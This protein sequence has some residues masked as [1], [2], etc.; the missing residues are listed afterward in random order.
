[1]T[2]KLTFHGAAGCVTG[3][4]ARLEAGRA[5]VLV[6][7]GMFQGSKTL[8]ALNYEPFPFD[9][10]AIDAVLLTHA[11]IDHSGLLPKLMKAGFEGP[12]Y[13]TAGTRDLCAVMLPDA[14]D[15]QESEVRQLNRRNQR[16]GRPEVEPIY[17]V[18]DARRCMELFR[19]V[20]LG[21]IAEVAPGI[22][23]TYWEAG[24]ILG[25]ASIELQVDTEEGP[26]SLMFSG[27]LG[28]GGRDYTPDPEGPV[29]VDHLILESTYGD[30]ER[31]TA[32]GGERRAL[33]AKELTEAHAAG[34]PLLI[35]AFAVERS[36]EL[37]ADIVTLME[38]RQVPEADIFLDSPLAIEATE[39]FQKRGWNR[40]TGVNPFEGL[41]HSGRLK[42]LNHPSESDQLD[43]LAGWHVII[44]ASGMCDAGRVRKHLKRLLWRR[45]ATVLI[46]GYQAVG[47]LGRILQEGA[48][49]VS[50]QGDDVQVRARIRSLDVYSGHADA[51]GLVAWAKAR[52]PVAGQIFLVHGE[53]AALDGLET[54]LE[55]A[56]FPAA[57]M[58]APAMDEAFLL[59]KTDAT[60]ESI[61]AR[62]IVAGAVAKADWHNARAQLLMELNERLSDAPNDRAREE[63]I[64]QLA[65]ALNRAS[66]SISSPSAVLLSAI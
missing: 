28:P 48:R 25:S 54:R 36:Q 17:A 50:I 20:K 63:I 8:K 66:S 65:G 19:K 60:S 16:R 6:D 21:E 24:H 10:H 55:T 39:V 33:L 37:L 43:R 44:A 26:V 5:T 4:C 14:G 53:P 34:G 58:A 64:A 40:A 29:G 31:L 12:I 7:C 15:I 38:D 18:Q 56:G 45:Q 41:R 46:S 30:R 13:A 62:R 1:M 47:T 57:Q 3:F 22:T 49:R 32:S 61:Q 2:L 11:H 59:A 35:P 23:A 42:F 51:A 9:A 27:D 52:A